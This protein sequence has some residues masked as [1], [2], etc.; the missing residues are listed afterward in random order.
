LSWRKKSYLC[1]CPGGRRATC[2]I[3][4]EEEELPV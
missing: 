4:L 2:V 1:D 3:V